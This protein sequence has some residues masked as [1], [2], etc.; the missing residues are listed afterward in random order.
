MTVM[1]KLEDL[2]DNIKKYWPLF[3]PEK[4]STLKQWMQRNC[5]EETLS[6]VITQSQKSELLFQSLVK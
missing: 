4:T 1:D 3:N 2:V 6:I 5:R